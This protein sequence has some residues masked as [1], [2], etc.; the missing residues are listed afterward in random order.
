MGEGK[1]IPESSLKEGGAFFLPEGARL[2]LVCSEIA[3]LSPA[4]HKAAS[5]RAFLDTTLYILQTHRGLD[6]ETAV[7]MAWPLVW[8]FLCGHLLG[9]V[10]L[11]GEERLGGQDQGESWGQG[12][13]SQ[14]CLV[15]AAGSH[16]A[17]LGRGIEGWEGK[18]EAS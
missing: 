3:N 17:R 13:A 16:C 12:R 4:Q 6:P 18:Q 10:C 7:A 1:I 5:L 8:A 11:S 14:A 9:F 15:P 2:C